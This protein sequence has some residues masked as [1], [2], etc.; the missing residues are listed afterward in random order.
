MGTQDTPDTTLSNPYYQRLLKFLDETNKESDR[1]SALITGSLI[2]QMLA[3]ILLAFFIDNKSSNDLI[4]AA[5]AP[6]SSFYAKTELTFSLGIISAVERRDI[7][8]VRKIRNKFAHSFEC[9]FEDNDISSWCSELKTG[10]RKLD[11]LPKGHKSRADQP[12]AR[13]SMVTTSIVSDLYN[14]AHYTK[15]KRRVELPDELKF[16]DQ[17]M[18]KMAA[19]QKVA[20]Q[21]TE[22]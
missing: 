3:E 15:K 6:L 1:G 8:F 13:F 5:N 16:L 7:N 17:V 9:S 11:E 21:E 14:R 10:M 12:K 20:R 22:D 19:D 18:E 4:Y 2:D